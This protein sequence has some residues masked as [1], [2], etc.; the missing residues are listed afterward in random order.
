MIYYIHREE[1]TETELFDRISYVI[2]E[3]GLTKTE[4]AK[5][6][7]ISQPH[8]SKISAGI[9]NPSD[10]TITDI[11]REFGVSEKW[12]RTGDGPKRI[13][14]TFQQE[15]ANLAGRYLNDAAEADRMALVGAILK[16]PRDQLV[17]IMDQVIAIGKALE[18][19][20][21][22]APDPPDG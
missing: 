2:E 18:A 11:C 7:N 10:R 16:L 6:I 20:R 8:L 13:P 17:P 5:R 1:V 9:S 12:L 22:H 19:A 14:Q 21:N 4:F 15:V 3:S